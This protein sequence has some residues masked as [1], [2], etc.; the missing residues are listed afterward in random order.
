MQKHTTESSFQKIHFIRI[1]DYDYI[2]T[3]DIFSSPL[4]YTYDFFKDYSVITHN[5]SAVRYSQIS[6]NDVVIIGGGGLFN[7]NPWFNFNVAINRILDLCD[8]VV[9]WGAGFNSHITKDGK[10]TEYSPLVDFSRF[11]LYGIRDRDF[12]DY[13]FVPCASAM[14]PLLEKAYRTRP[15]KKIGTIFRTDE[16]RNE[17][18]LQLEGV[19]NLTHYN[20]YTTVMDFISAHEYIVTSSYHGALWATLANRKVIVPTALKVGFKYNYY[21]FPLT[22]IDDASSAK[23]LAA[24]MGQAKR[25]P[26]VLHD[27]RS[28]NYDFFEKVKR[29]VKS[30]ILV[31]D[32]SYEFFYKQNEAAEHYFKFKQI[33]RNGK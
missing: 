25:N 17:N 11:A 19:Q 29:L 7:Y 9:V 15:T 8:N 13:N 6:K 32:K 30:V 23:R 1:I 5:L 16:V 31:P 24:A 2:N 14:S 4:M 18:S 22:F 33:E 27:Y 12:E 28:K 26:D 21:G 20:N 10:L 3:G